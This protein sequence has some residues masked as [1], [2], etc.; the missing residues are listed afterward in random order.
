MVAQSIIELICDDLKY[1]DKQNDPQYLMLNN[2]LREEKRINKVKKSMKK[3]KKS[4]NTHSSNKRLKS[5]FSTKYK[6]RIESIRES[7]KKV[8]E[9][10]KKMMQKRKKTPQEIR[11]EMLRTLNDK[12]KKVEK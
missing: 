10:Q 4:G 1:Q 8:Q 6:D 5:K 11:E 3:K 2:K 7:D 9:K 12:D